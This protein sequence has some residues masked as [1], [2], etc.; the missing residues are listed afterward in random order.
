MN[1]FKGTNI[2]LSRCTWLFLTMSNKT[3]V[4]AS[5]TIPKTSN[6]SFARYML[7]NWV[8]KVSRTR[9]YGLSHYSKSQYFVQKSWGW[10]SNFFVLL[11]QNMLTL[12]LLPKYAPIGIWT[13]NFLPNIS[14]IWIQTLNFLLKNSQSDLNPQ[15][16]CQKCS[17]LDLNPQH[18]TRKFS[19]SGFVQSIFWIKIGL[20]TQ[21][22]PITIF[23]LVTI[24]ITMLSS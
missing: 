24:V 9:K 2:S 12:L 18:F 13:H 19:H 5:W 15:L 20:S 3:M 23:N 8:K 7:S 21:W 22:E 6:H 10:K 1:P 4:L 16:F 11:C 17:S 14:H